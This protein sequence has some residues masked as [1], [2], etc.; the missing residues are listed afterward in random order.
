MRM[1]E[2]KWARKKL[3]IFFFCFKNDCKIGEKRPHEN[4]ISCVMHFQCVP[5][6][7]VC[8]VLYW[9]CWLDGLIHFHL[10]QSLDCT[11]THARRLLSP[12]K[13]DKPFSK[14]NIYREKKPASS[15]LFLRCFFHFHLLLLIVIGTFQVVFV[16]LHIM[17]VCT[18][19][20]YLSCIGRS[21]FIC[22]L[23]IFFFVCIFPPLLR[24]RCESV[25]WN[26]LAVSQCV[27]YVRTRTC[28]S[29]DRFV[30]V[31]YLD[32]CWRSSLLSRWL[33]AQWQRTI[34]PNWFRLENR[35]DYHRTIVIVYV[36][37]RRIFKLSIP[38]DMNRLMDMDMELHKFR[39][40]N[41]ILNP[42]TMDTHSKFIS[43]G[44]KNK[45][46]IRS[47]IS[48][49]KYTIA[50][51]F[52][53]NSFDLQCHCRFFTFWSLCVIDQPNHRW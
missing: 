9:L 13:R 6:I 27:H 15:T 5:S 36:L 26:V 33:C 18:L 4:A 47:R 22:L 37:L 23:V 24:L 50:H 49:E 20:L 44:S 39:V 30:W 1:H 29:R 31:R 38:C 19:C 8:W 12:E 53:I 17:Y 48:R 16:G 45:E 52:K 7:S 40:S 34:P 51:R 10:F 28:R 41:K 14:V 2:Y 11:H 46:W 43:S 3:K 21:T 35:F 25:K 32:F 42:H